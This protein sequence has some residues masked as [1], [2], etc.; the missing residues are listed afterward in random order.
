MSCVCGMVFLCGST[1]VKGP[2]LQ[3]GTVVVWPQIF[4]SDVKPKTN[5]QKKCVSPSRKLSSWM[6]TMHPNC[7]KNSL[8]GLLCSA[9]YSWPQQSFRPRPVLLWEYRHRH[10]TWEYFQGFCSTNF[11][12]ILKILQDNYMY[13]PIWSLWSV[14]ENFLKS[15]KINIV[16]PWNPILILNIC[17]FDYLGSPCSYCT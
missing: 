8:V 4:K 10:K 11:F 12:R 16:F 7:D 6:I 17:P 14:L 3:A 1:L 9:T 15:L 5:K 13:R 2:L